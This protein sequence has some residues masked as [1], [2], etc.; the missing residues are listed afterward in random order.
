MFNI[1]KFCWLCVLGLLAVRHPYATD[2]S[3]ADASA[4]TQENTKQIEYTIRVNQNDQYLTMGQIN[5]RQVSFIVDTGAT[6]VDI[7][8]SIAEGLELSKG[9][10]LQAHTA[11]GL[12]K[13]YKTVIADLWIGPIHLRDIEASI[14][15]SAQY[16]MILLGMSALKQL[17]ISQ[18]NGSLHL[19][20]KTVD[21]SVHQ[22]KFKKSV[23]D[24]LGDNKV[25]NQQTLKC[26]RGELAP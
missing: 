6:S 24:C 13:A 17:Q 2:Q 25:I 19:S 20:R 7:P 9:E 15:P 26:M 14:N 5:G 4:P 11:G 8:Q 1:K 12:V 10:E 16:P 3:I 18:E 23:K 21:G 22:E